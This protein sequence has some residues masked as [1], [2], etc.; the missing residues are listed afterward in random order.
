[1]NYLRG[2]K[3]TKNDKILENLSTERSLIL[4]KINSTLFH[5]GKN[6]LPKERERIK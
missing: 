2:G 1:M 3:E 6:I 5:K 4:P